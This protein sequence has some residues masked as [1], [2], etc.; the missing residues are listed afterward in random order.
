[1]PDTID[2]TAAPDVPALA[3]PASDVVPEQRADT[4]ALGTSAIE[5][6]APE[7]LLA[8]DV[9]YAVALG[10]SITTLYRVIDRPE[11]ERTETGFLPRD[12]ELT[13][14][15]ATK[16]Y[17]ERVNVGTRRLEHRLD[18]P[19]TEALRVLT[20]ELAKPRSTRKSVIA[21]RT[22]IRDL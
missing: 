10:W 4:E 11:G 18:A 7:H 9:V 15:E 20:E 2:L 14:S 6:D 17:L 3:P 21:T 5:V 12:D 22:H 13:A 16:R 1:M 8:D 19:P